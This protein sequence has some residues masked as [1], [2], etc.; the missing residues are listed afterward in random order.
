MTTTISEP[1]NLLDLVGQP[2]GPGEWLTVPQSDI[3]MFAKAT[4]DEQWIHVDVERAK[5]G[6]FGRTIAH[7]YLTLALLVP[8]WSDLL[9]IEKL[10]MGVNYGLNKVRFPAPV[11]AN[12]RVRLAATITSVEEIPGHGEQLVV[13]GTI[14]CDQAAKPVCVAEIVLRYYA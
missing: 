3:D 8:L 14:E 7:G 11:P 4:H 9:V 2:L 5:T 12:S 6:P 10:R 13:A 1:K